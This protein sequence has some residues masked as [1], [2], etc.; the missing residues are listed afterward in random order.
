MNR[1]LFTI[2]ASVSKYLVVAALGCNL[3]LAGYYFYQRTVVGNPMVLGYDEHGVFTQLSR[4]RYLRQK[5]EA[6]ERD[7][8]KK[9]DSQWLKYKHARTAA[10]LVAEL[11][12]QEE[13][14]AVEKEG[15]GEADG[16]RQ[17]ADALVGGDSTARG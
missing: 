13:A 7:I 16:D 12:A 17:A 15:E 5:L 9:P 10:R 6:L 3:S 14:R 11:N 4:E 2:P 8:A 1:G